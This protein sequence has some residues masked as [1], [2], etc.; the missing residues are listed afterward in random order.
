M[1]GLPASPPGATPPQAALSAARAPPPPQATARRRVAARRPL[2][3]G[4]LP[5]RPPSGALNVVRFGPATIVLL[6][7][8]AAYGAAGASRGRS[9]P[10]GLSRPGPAAAPA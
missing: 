5:M 2:P 9:R 1:A 6:V 10:P 4:R 7:L 8:T 3:R